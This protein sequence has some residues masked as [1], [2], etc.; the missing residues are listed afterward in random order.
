M[1]KGRGVVEMWQAAVKEM[2]AQVNNTASCNLI[3]PPIAVRTVCWRF[4]NTMK[5]IKEISGVCVSQ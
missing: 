2:N 5:V 1:V 4:D 3:D